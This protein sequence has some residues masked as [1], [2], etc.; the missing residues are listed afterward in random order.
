MSSLLLT[1]I[2]RLLTTVGVVA[3]AW[4]AVCVL[5]ML[6]GHNDALPGIGAVLV[7]LMDRL[8]TQPVHDLAS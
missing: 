5:A 8:V 1:A 7:D 3:L 4:L 6:T 2:A